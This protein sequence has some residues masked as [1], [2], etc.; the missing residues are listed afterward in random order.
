MTVHDEDLAIVFANVIIAWIAACLCFRGDGC[1]QKLPYVV[2]V[3]TEDE[4]IEI[5]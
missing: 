4:G 2:A 5:G 3:Q 1:R